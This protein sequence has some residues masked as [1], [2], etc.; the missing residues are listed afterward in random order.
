MHVNQKWRK[1]GLIQLI[2]SSD[3]ST[4]NKQCK[5]SLL[6]FSLSPFLP[7]TYVPLNIL[8]KFAFF[9][10]V[11]YALCTLFITSSKPAYL[12]EERPGPASYN[13]GMVKDTSKGPK[14]G[15]SICRRVEE[16][17]GKIESNS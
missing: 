7:T 13:C 8:H 14:P 9:K 15:C 6:T 2:I 5:Y 1:L 4:Y 17:F 3:P 16:S 10:A 12:I 11:F